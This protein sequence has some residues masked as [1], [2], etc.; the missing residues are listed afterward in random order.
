MNTH[1]KPFLPRLALVTLSLSLC[2]PSARAA[3]APRAADPRIEQGLTQLGSRDPAARE[4]AR[5]TLMGLSADALEPLVTASRSWSASQTE[6]LE[7]IVK[8]ALIRSKIHPAD[9]SSQ[10]FLG[11]TFITSGSDDVDPAEAPPRGVPVLPVPGFVAARF[12]FDGDII[13]GVGSGK[14]LRLTTTPEQFRQAVSSYS[15]GEAITLQVQRGASVVEVT[16]TAD[17]RPADAE[18]T[19]MMGDRIERAVADAEQEWASRFQ[20]SLVLAQ[21]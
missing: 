16:L 17:R 9:G 19:L 12:L 18:D 15:A 21:R 5:E 14:S 10:A 3:D 7:A 8:Y 2:I 1:L 6:A 20:P 4:A 13:L 11:V